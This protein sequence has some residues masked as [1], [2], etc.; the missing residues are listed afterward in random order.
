VTGVQTCA[1]PIYR[2]HATEV[3]VADAAPGIRSIDQELNETVVL[4]D[5]H[6]SLAWTAAD[7]YFA[8]QSKNPR[9]REANSPAGLQ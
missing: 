1:L 6:A 4:Q 9:S 2:L 8:L 3:N 7:Q 5:G